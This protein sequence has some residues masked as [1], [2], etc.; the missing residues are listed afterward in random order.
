[1]GADTS[2]GIHA[3]TELPPATTVERAF[4]RRIEGLPLQTREGLVVVAADSGVAK[5]VL[6]AC[7]LLGLPAS[8][9]DPAEEAGVIRVGGGRIAFT[10]PLLRAAVY[11]A[12]SAVTR[13]RI[14][15]H[16]RRSLAEEPGATGDGG[17]LGP[18]AKM[19]RAWQL[20]R[21]GREPDETVASAL[22]AAACEARQRSGYAAAAAGLE[23]AARL[24][25]RAENACG[26]TRGVGAEI[27]IWPANWTQ[28]PRCSTRRS[29][30][31]VTRGR[32]RRSNTCVPHRH[33]VGPIRSG[34]DLVGH[35]SRLGGGGGSR[36]CRV[37]A[38]G[39][40]DL[41]VDGGSRRSSRPA[42]P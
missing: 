19:R 4:L 38:H 14:T 13:D 41:G 23:R 27:G 11:H 20:A 33:V 15:V 10:H 25:P 34:I 6:D 31:L 1:M 5:T 42:C 2:G 26:T 30:S 16:L 39:C 21:C 29:G 37:H 9:L 36:D 24:T 18:T 12:A 28:P 7:S 17:P 22:E 3:D 32:G 35:R 40:R 8:C